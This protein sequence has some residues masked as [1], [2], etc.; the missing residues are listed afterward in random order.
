VNESLPSGT[1]IVSF[2]GSSV[3]SGTYFYTLRTQQSSETK[4]MILLK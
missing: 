3:P 2:D 1:H 4:K